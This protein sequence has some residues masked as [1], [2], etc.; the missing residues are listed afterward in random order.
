M[1]T[2][3]SSRSRPTHR[4]M[5]SWLRPLR[6]LRWQL[7]YVYSIL[8]GVLFL[9]FGE[10]IYMYKTIPPALI[11]IAAICMMGVTFLILLFFTGALLNPL[12]RLTEAGQAIAL[13][14]LKQRERLPEGD[15]EVGKLA[16]ILNE[17]VDQLEQSHKMGQASEERTKQLLSDASHQLRTP[18]TSLYGF[19]QVLM[20]GAKDDPE[21]LQRVLKVM[22]NEAERMTRLV[23]DLLTLVRLEGANSL[24]TRSVDLVDLATESLE[25][26]RRK[27]TNGQKVRLSIAI[28]HC[29]VEADVE[30]LK[31][32]LQILFDNALK[33]GCQADDGTVCLRVAKDDS[34]ALLQVIDNGPGIAPDDL[35]HIF[36]RFYRGKQGRLISADGTPIVGTGLGL[37]LAL[38]IARAHHGD[39]LIAS[40]PDKE[41]VFTVT[42]PCMDV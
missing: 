11:G 42:L 6:S 12:R 3:D 4:S 1:P 7:T 10:L 9:L 17:L 30:Y 25:Q 21:T 2:F 23:S 35:P 15:D 24:H 31:Q 38:A 39:I 8:M 16:A 19:T 36:E 22:G 26:A 5:P 32:L 29:C 27:A 14:D 41:T 34:N 28:Q 18:L 33:Y 13:G 37:S 20:R 40:E